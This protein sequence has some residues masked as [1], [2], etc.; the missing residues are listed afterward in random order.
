MM[1]VG[2]GGIHPG[3]QELFNLPQMWDDSFIPG[4]EKMVREV[5]QYDVLFG[6]QLMHGGRQAYLDEIKDFP[7]GLRINGDDYSI[8]VHQQF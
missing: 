4:L 2:G 8:H 6:V 5:K 7:I 1:L 3:G